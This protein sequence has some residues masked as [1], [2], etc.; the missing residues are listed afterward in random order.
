[1][2]NL[3][4]GH[5]LAVSTSFPCSVQEITKKEKDIEASNSVSQYIPELN[6]HLTEFRQATSADISA[7]D[8]VIIVALFR[9]PKSLQVWKGL[10]EKP[11]TT[12]VLTSKGQEVM[13]TGIEIDLVGFTAFSV[14]VD[15]ADTFV[16]LR[17]YL[18]RR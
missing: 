5:I 15:N 11:G 10:R 9:E 1:V 14:A 16:P 8:I 2:K 13:L 3:V 12:V 7:Y 6:C 17:S 4:G 18:S